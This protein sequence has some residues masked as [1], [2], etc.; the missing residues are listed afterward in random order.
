VI[1]KNAA[2]RTFTQ[3]GKSG[4]TSIEDNIDMFRSL[5]EE[6]FMASYQE[7]LDE[8]WASFD[9]L[10]DVEYNN[11]FLIA[12][13]ENPIDKIDVSKNNIYRFLW[14]RTFHRPAVFTLQYSPDGESVLNI[15]MSDG[16][17]GYLPGEV[18]LN[19]T[20]S[21]SENEAS[22]LVKMFNAQDLCSDVASD[23]GGFDGSQ[24]VFQSATKQMRCESQIWTPDEGS[25]H[26]IGM[27]FFK[28]S[29]MNE[30]DFYGP[31]Y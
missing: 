8:F 14:L 11:A 31:V 21:I 28:L 27:M 13:G 24:W 29:G 30:A 25:L 2:H 3:A 15:K 26:D 18:V 10:S 22:K 23:R 20:I 5:A 4:Q 19:N 16:S 1:A 9:M 7:E 6:I 12:L 17:G